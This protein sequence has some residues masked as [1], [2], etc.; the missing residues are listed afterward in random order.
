M[1]NSYRQEA[2]TSYVLPSILMPDRFVDISDDS[3]GVAINLCAQFSSPRFHDVFAIH[4]RAI[5]KQSRCL[6]ISSVS[7]EPSSFA[8][9]R[10]Q[11]HIILLITFDAQPRMTRWF[12]S[13]SSV[14]ARVT[15]LHRQG[16]MRRL[17]SLSCLIPVREVVC[18]LSDMNL[19]TLG[20]LISHVLKRR[21]HVAVVCS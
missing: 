5:V 8:Q 7:P 10:N 17:V 12:V 21:A 9:G 11:Y 15:A 13:L 3:S 19:S 4:L 1:A 20:S 18:G 6:T 14:Q 16:I 2:M